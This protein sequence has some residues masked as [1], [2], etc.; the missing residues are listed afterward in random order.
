MDE[1]KALLLEIKNQQEEQRLATQE[2]RKE[3]L[4]KIESTVIVKLQEV[5]EKQNEIEEKIKNQE[6]AIENFE[7]QLRKRNLIFFGIHETEQNYFELQ[8]RILD[9]I[10]D[11]YLVKCEDNEIQEV[12]RIGK[13][14]LNPRPVVVCFSTFAK[15]L[16][17]LKKSKTIQTSHYVK[18]D[19]PKNVLLKR[20][21]LQEI[22]KTERENGRLVTIKYDKLIYLD[23]KKT[24]STIPS[25]ERQT[26]TAAK[27]QPSPSQQNEKTS[28]QKRNMS[29][30]PVVPENEDGPSGKNL[31]KKNKFTTMK[32]YVTQP[33]PKQ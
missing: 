23:K 13:K 8:N 3:I 24:E 20:R 6:K 27:N 29:T 15:K 1:M 33:K 2:L 4:E 10:N 31:P 25:T 32:N 5:T 12:Y 16:S 28:K 26:S 30:S 9:I 19:F 21:E 7:K 22:A 14:S 17:I 11:E 18:Q